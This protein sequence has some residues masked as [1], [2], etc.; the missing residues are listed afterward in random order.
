M[1][2]SGILDK[3]LQEREGQEESSTLTADIHFL[4]WNYDDGLIHS[5]EKEGSG[6]WQCTHLSPISLTHSVYI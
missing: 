5:P 6:Q 2:D 3:L 1:N 4:C